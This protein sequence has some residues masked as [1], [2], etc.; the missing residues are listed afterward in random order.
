MRGE[1]LGR[2]AN[3]VSPT[4]PRVTLLTADWSTARPRCGATGILSAQTENA[5]GNPGGKG[6]TP[7]IKTRSVNE[8]IAHTFGAQYA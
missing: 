8:Y 6:N 4:R 7:W 2:T 3:A 1:M 5:R